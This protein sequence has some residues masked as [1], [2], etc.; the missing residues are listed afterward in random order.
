[1]TA[2]HNR[3]CHIG[4]GAPCGPQGA[5]EAVQQFGFRGWWPSPPGAV[6]DYWPA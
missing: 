3:Y 5:T 4:I 1:M 6:L 2:R